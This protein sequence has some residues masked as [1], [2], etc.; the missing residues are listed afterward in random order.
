VQA[1]DWKFIAIATYKYRKE[2]KANLHA[3][4]E[5][6]NPFI[7]EKPNEIGRK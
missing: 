5:G 4:R 7:R 2:I 6:T 3:S 1:L